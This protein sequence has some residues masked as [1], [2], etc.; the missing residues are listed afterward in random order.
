MRREHPH[1]KLV[2]VEDA[3]AA[4]GPHIKLLQS[5]KLRYILGVKPGDH[6]FLFDW[7]ATTPGVQSAALTGE[8]GTVHRFRYLNGAPLNESHFDLQVNFLA[9]EEQRP[10][11]KVRH[12]TWVTDI[13]L[14][15]A[16]LLRVMRGARARWKIENE[17]FNTLKH[18]GYHFEHNL[19]H[20]YQH[21]S[22]VL[23]YLMML[24]FLV[25]QVQQHCC[26]LFQ[27]A[28]AKEKYKRYFWETL[29]SFF[30]TWLLPDWET[31]YRALAYGAAPRVLT[32]YDT[33]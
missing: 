30:F 8:D 3:L 28:S 6:A 7:V 24:T 32:P 2:V 5:L 20:G 9:Y 10:S 1:L 33:S 17:T 11:G 22:T 23:A 26:G 31:L 13:P 27:Q 25:D 4:N 29:P 18:Q 21:L 19:K 15:E 16:N 14:H 12:F